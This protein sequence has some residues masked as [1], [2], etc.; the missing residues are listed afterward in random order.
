[1]RRLRTLIG[2][3]LAAAAAATP[4]VFAQSR[5]KVDLELVLAVDISV[6]MS[7]DELQIQREGYAAALTDPEVVSAITSG[8]YGR[9]A[10]AY[11]E[12]AGVTSQKLIVPWT[13]IGDAR[14][15]AAFAARLDRVP[16]QQPRRTSISGAINFGAD[17]LAQSPYEAGRRVIDIS[18]DGSNNEGPPVT[19]ARDDAVAEGIVINGLPVMADEVNFSGN[20]VAHLDVYYRN[21]VIGG[22]GSFVIAINDWAEF[23]AAIRRKMLLEIARRPPAQPAQPPVVLAQ[24][25]APYDCL[26][27]E[28]LYRDDQFRH[29]FSPEKFQWPSNR[30]ENWPKQ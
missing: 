18:G 8:P 7:R 29:R 2:M 12:W 1:M 23:P 19:M 16:A 26:V 6:S 21:C 4:P 15:A 28:R 14:D 17:L 3:C 25:T 9:I 27:G 13:M 24:A 10:L 11:F 30:P 22:P 20:D 5:E